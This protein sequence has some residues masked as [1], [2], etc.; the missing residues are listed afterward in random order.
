MKRPKVNS[1]NVGNPAQLVAGHGNGARLAARSRLHDTQ[2]KRARLPT[3]KR[4]RRRELKQQGYL[5][6]LSPS[7]MTSRAQWP[8][9]YRASDSETVPSPN[10]ILYVPRYGWK[11]PAPKKM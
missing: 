3:G 8:Q 7:S 2:D 1:L 10:M 4:A 5:T 9:W 11:M 6:I